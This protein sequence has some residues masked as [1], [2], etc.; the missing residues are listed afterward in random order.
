MNTPA[1]IVLNT[2]VLGRGRWRGHAG[3]IALGALTPDLPMVGFF[4]YQRLALARPDELIWSSIYFQPAW[5][6]F[7]DCFNSLPLILVAAVMAWRMRNT[8]GTAFFASMAVHCLAD[9]AL[10]HDDA[11]RHFY[12][13]SEWR[14]ES[15][16]S[17]WDPQHY[18]HV[19]M[20]VE[21]LLVV[22]GTLYLMRRGS[23]RGERLL[24]ASVLA[25]YVVFIAYAVTS[26]GA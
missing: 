19:A 22:L 21:M 17:Y 18:G 2:V 7:F 20:P 15:P 10:H 1:H 23:P 9:L 26:W 3:A 5:Q 4:L 6:A 25:S 12:P 11:H 24:G 16:V 8:A 13:F 14:F